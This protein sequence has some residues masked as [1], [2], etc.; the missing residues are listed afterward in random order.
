[1]L[2]SRHRSDELQEVVLIAI[3]QRLQVVVLP[4]RSIELRHVAPK[5]AW[6]ASRHE[7]RLVLAQQLQERDTY[8]R[9]AQVE[10]LLQLVRRTRDA[11]TA[12][13]ELCQPVLA[14]EELPDHG[15][16]IIIGQHRKR[17]HD[18]LDALQ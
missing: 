6:P 18:L 12:Y 14:A 3:T 7:P 9:V 4:D 8:L 5:A 10:S 13:R 17:L 16:A 11:S 1:M 15:R 2:H